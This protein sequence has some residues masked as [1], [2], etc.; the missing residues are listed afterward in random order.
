[1][2]NI[3]FVWSDGRRVEHPSTG[4]AVRVYNFRTYDHGILWHGNPLIFEREDVFAYAGQSDDGT[5]EYVQTARHPDAFD[6]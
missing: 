5:L 4:I 3:A 2:T 1:M 6:L